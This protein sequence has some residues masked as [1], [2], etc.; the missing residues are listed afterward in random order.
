MIDYRKIAHCI[1]YYTNLGYQYT[2]VPWTV[3]PKIHKITSPPDR[4]TYHV[5]KEDEST[6][7]LVASGEQSFLELILS[8]K[9]SNNQPYICTTPCFRQE[10]AYDIFHRGHFIKSELFIAHTNISTTNKTLHNML[11]TALDFFS[12][13]VKC[14][15]IKT[16]ESETSHDIV[17]SVGQIELGSY[18]IRTFKNTTWVYGTALAEPRLSTAINYTKGL[19]I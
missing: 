15:V 17:T 14:E 16:E 2:E 3:D 4:F 7:C 8:G 12:S 13:C 9:I 18:G 5:I 19:I 1:Q 11:H 6:E 10:P